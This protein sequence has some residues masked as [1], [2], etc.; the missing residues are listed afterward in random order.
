MTGF[1][2]LSSLPQSPLTIH[3][4]HKL[5][6]LPLLKPFVRFQRA[7]FF[8]SRNLSYFTAAYK[9]PN[10]SFP[11]ESSSQLSEDD[12]EADSDDDEDDVAAE[13]YDAVSGEIREDS[14]GE[15]EEEDDD[16]VLEDSGGIGEKIGVS[17]SERFEELKW[18]RVERIRNEVREFGEEIIDV[19]ELASVYNFRIDKF[20]VFLVLRILGMYC[21]CDSFRLRLECFFSC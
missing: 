7:Q 12:N 2:L 13:E 11:V 8:H 1:S 17:G 4:T 15:E 16:G 14:E 10:S 21:I 6:P 3:S 9:F 18:Q 20:Q 5:S 19:E